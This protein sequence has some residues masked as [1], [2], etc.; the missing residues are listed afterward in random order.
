MLTTAEIK[1]KKELED[2]KSVYPHSMTE[3]KHEKLAELSKLDNVKVKTNNH[4]IV[5]WQM[6]R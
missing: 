5:D 1:E 2:L 4:F 6:A 3:E